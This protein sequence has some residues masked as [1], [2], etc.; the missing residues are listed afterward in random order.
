MTSVAIVSLDTNWISHTKLLRMFDISKVLVS[1][2][3]CNSRH[4]VD[5]VDEG[6]GG[7]TSYQ[8]ARESE[9]LLVCTFV[10]SRP[11]VGEDLVIQSSER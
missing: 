9:K 6:S 1:L 8:R 7:R 3:R 5:D 4:V 2:L 10:T 11:R